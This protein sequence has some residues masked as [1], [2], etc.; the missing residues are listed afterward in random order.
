MSIPPPSTSPAN[1]MLQTIFTAIVAES[2]QD[3]Y[4]TLMKTI[5]KLDFHIPHQADEF[6]V[7]QSQ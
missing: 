2:C 6:L 1:E 5:W 7:F 3:L 4:P